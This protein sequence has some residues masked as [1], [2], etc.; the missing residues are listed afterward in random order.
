MIDSHFQKTNWFTNLSVIG[1]ISLMVMIFMFV[2]S[3]CEDVIDVTL[4]DGDEAL[5]VDAW[6]N[7]LAEDQVISLNLSQPYFDNSM[8]PAVQDAEVTVT[9]E[10]GLIFTFD[11][12]IGGTYIWESNGE[13]LGAI[14]DRF[15]LTISY[16]GSLY[17]SETQLYRVPEIDS[18]IIEFRE[19]EL[20]AGDGLY[21]EFFAR[22]LEGLGDTYWIKTYKN[23]EFLSKSQSLNLAF[24]AG[25]DAGTGID[26]L[27]FYSSYTRTD[28]SVG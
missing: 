19:D 6:I 12:T 4:E 21:A 10:D 13:S 23:D 27:G 24:D 16:D 25:F 17:K 3:S 15:T 7:D 2:L 9:R 5:V 20:F 28:Q 8:P 26:G 14:N 22:D 11:H 1:I 18:I